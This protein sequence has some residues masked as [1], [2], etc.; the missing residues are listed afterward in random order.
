MG[1]SYIKKKQE[2]KMKLCN[3]NNSLDVTIEKILE[4]VQ[5]VMSTCWA[6]GSTDPLSRIS[7]YA[8]FPVGKMIRPRLLLDAYALV[9]GGDPSAL[10]AAAG[11]E[12]AHVASLIHDDIIDQD[13]T[14]RGRDAVHHR[15]GMESALLAGDMLIFQAFLALVKC[16]EKG[17]SAKRVIKAV[18]VV[19]SVGA[20]ICRGQMLEEQVSGDLTCNQDVYLQVIRLKTASLFRG[21]MMCGAILGGGSDEQVAALTTYGEHLGILFQIVDD[22]L[23]YTG[24]FEIL[25]KPLAS[26]LKNR[27]LTLPI[28]LAYQ[29]GEPFIRDR[30]E[31]LFTGIGIRKG[32]YV[33]LQHILEATSAIQAARIV[34]AEHAEKAKSVLHEFE[35]SISG[36]RL[37]SY[38]PLCLNRI[39]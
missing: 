36:Q 37:Q 15:Y 4:D 21:A 34:A 20:D 38:I 28:I 35:P 18:E 26:D 30:I 13:T 19:A 24:N 23:C 10:P 33:E 1:N 27:R 25:G 6:G 9:G 2:K 14:R 22:L 11:A 16:H 39:K 31:Y 5:Q 29:G 8:L 3:K 17:I 32:D 12:F 7:R